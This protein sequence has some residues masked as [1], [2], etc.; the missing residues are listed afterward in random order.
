MEFLVG[1][2]GVDVVI[3]IKVLFD[4]LV[5]FDVFLKEKFFYFI[6]VLIY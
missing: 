2:F 1:L 5:K 4:M 6:S 3:K